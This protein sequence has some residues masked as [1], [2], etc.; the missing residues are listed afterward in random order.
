MELIGG[1]IGVICIFALTMLS[2]TRVQCIKNRRIKM[3]LNN[4]KN[5]KKKDD[6]LNRRAR[7][8]K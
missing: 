6:K 5:K 3:R 4:I 7:D 8:R 1:A 2:T